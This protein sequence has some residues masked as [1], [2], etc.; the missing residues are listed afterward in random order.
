M[1]VTLREGAKA[2]ARGLATIVVLP[3]VGSY[4]LRSC[5]LG[6]DRAL[7]GSTQALGLVPG[8]TGQY[9]RR[10]FLRL[11]LA[12]FHHSAT[13]EFGTIFS[14][15]DARIDAHAYIGPRCHLGL[16]HIGTDAMLAA[17]VH[18][19]SGA[20]THGMDD[21]DAPMRLQAGRRTRVRIADGS[22]IGSGA[23][24]MADV[25]RDTVVGAGAVVTSSLPDRVV[26]VG[27]PARVLRSRDGEAGGRWRV[28][29]GR[30]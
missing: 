17:G 4:W 29:G 10:A 23:V 26:A 12:H 21:P 24:V 9:L 20:R 28:G 1:R 13:V 6:R 7:E 15:A 16:V 18:V 3:A 14:R 11:T 8:L 30:R 5:V 2:A 25:G 22:W 27:V 19:P